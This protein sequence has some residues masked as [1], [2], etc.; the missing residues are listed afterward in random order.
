VRILG[1]A[2]LVILLTWLLLGWTPGDAITQGDGTWLVIP[3]TEQL[4]QAG[5]DWTANLY[6]IGVL[7]GSEMHAFGGALPVAQLAIHIGLSATSTA[8]VVTMFVQ[9]CY[10]FFGVRLAIALASSWT[11]HERALTSAQRVAAIWLVGFAP[12]LGWRLVLGHENLLLGFLPL[13]VCVS[14]LWQARAGQ[15]SSVSLVFATFA[16]VNGV[17]GM[18]AQALVYS[19]IF[20]LP[21]VIAS[22]LPSRTIPRRAFGQIAIAMLAGL[23]VAAPRLVSMV[24]HAIGPDA[25][26]GVSNT[27]STSYGVAPIS[28]FLGSLPWTIAGRT[29]ALHEHNYPVGALILIALV[30]TFRYRPR[31]LLL[32]MWIVLAIAIGFACELAPFSWL[33]DL[34][35]ILRAFRGP[36]RAVI[37]VLAF[38][39]SLALA[40]WSAS[41]SKSV[42]A[43]DEPADDSATSPRGRAGEWLAVVAGAVVI[44]VARNGAVPWVREVA[45]W[46][47]AIAVCIHVRIDRRRLPV[48]AV[49]ALFIVLAALGVAAFAERIPRGVPHDRLEDG[50]SLLREAAR[51]ELP[52][53]QTA[54]DRVEIAQPP[55]PFDMSMAFAAGLPSIDGVWYPPKRFL[56]LLSQLDG[57]E[58]PPTTS[59]FRNGGGRASFPVL[60]QLY[61]IRALLLGVG[62]DHARVQVLP[63]TPGAAWFP[64]QIAT[65]EQPSEMIEDIRKHGLDVIG[66]RGWLLRGDA[67]DTPR[68]CAGA[69]V[70]SVSTEE[71]GQRAK[72]EIVAPTRCV[73]I[74]S[75]NFA[76]TLRAR[77]GTNLLRVF[78]IDIA[79]TGVDV[80]AGTTQIVIG[81]VLVLPWWSRVLQLIGLAGVLAVI[82]ARFYARMRS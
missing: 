27:V 4:R 5:G 40:L 42:T 6:R 43:T 41:A 53:L 81:P 66:Q 17:S 35:P 1:E 45:A 9:L 12:L 62:T 79:L 82:A 67:D 13:F 72:L 39:P 74:V 56:V 28:D 21:I 26:R 47:I 10:G 32:T 30:G 49:H 44:I 48:V 24:Q 71:L 33:N 68:S 14:L 19:A 23:L 59:V 63:P 46:L 77:S 20:G 22:A 2:M 73:L 50:P 69:R 11:T 15:L 58:L 38:V 76:S 36:S 61:N 34:I 65:I 7:G 75:M 51:S 57:R 78:P 31:S 55:P 3:Y 80:P 70:T 29:G 18:G 54:F 8:N 60:Q 64:T 25:T 37:A 16:T 52:Q